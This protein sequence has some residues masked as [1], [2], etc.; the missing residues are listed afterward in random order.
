MQVFTEGLSNKLVGAFHNNDIKKE[1]GIVFRVFGENTEIMIDRER[2]QRNMKLIHSAGQ[3]PALYAKF[4]N[5]I[6]YG[7]VSGVTLDMH[8]MRDRHIGR[9]KAEQPY[10]SCIYT[11]TTITM[12]LLPSQ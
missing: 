7:F 6:A 2:E 8:T 10:I 3:G 5:G 9:Y 11:R 1:D 4:N 12:V